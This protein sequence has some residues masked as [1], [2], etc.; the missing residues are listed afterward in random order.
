MVR[1]PNLVVVG[2][3]KCGTTSLYHYLKQHPEVYLP[4]RKELHYF[5]RAELARDTAGPGDAT[6]LQHLRQAPQKPSEIHA[7]VPYELDLI[8][9]KLLAKRAMHGYEVM[10]ALEEE[11]HGCYKP[12]PGTVYPTLQWLEDEGLVNAE[13]VEG[14]KK[15]KRRYARYRYY[16]PGPFFYAHPRFWWPWYR[17]HYRYYR[18]YRRHYYYGPPFPFFRW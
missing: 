4:T 16:H 12:S 9:L 18:P 11:T 15:R 17:P 1:L 8:I 6:V 14:K 13:T 10:K 3:L 2:A 5:T 7:L